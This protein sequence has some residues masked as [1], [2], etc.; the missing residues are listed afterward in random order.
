MSLSNRIAPIE[1]IKVW[2]KERRVERIKR[3]RSKLAAERQDL[4]RKLEENEQLD[5]A[6]SDRE[7][8]LLSEIEHSGVYE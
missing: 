6:L 1:V 2:S 8:D 5:E 7:G 4:Y 3:K